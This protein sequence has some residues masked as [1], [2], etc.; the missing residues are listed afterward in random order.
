M[1]TYEYVKSDGAMGTVQ[2]ENAD[3][4]IKLAPG[5]AKNSG[6]ALSSPP[7]TSSISSTKGINTIKN[8]DKKM[9]ELDP[10]KIDPV[11]GRPNMSATDTTS[12]PS[13]KNTAQ[14]YVE[15]YNPTNERTMKISNVNQN[16]NQIK[17]LMES[18]FE[19][20]E[21]NTT[22]QI[23]YQSGQTEPTQQS[24]DKILKEEQ[25][26]LEQ[27]KTSNAQLAGQIDSIKADYDSRITIMR[28][29]GERREQSFQT[30][31]YR[32]GGRFTG[33]VRGGVF[34]GVISE[35]ER[36]GEARINT[37]DAQK[38]AEIEAAKQA[39]K[40]GNWKVYVQAVNNT[41]KIFEKQVKAVTDYNKAVKT[42]NDKLQKQLIE[43]SQQGSIIDLYKQG[44]T[45]PLDIYDYLNFDDSGNQIG[46]VS[47]TD[48]SSILGDIKKGSG[49]D[50]TP[51][52][53]RKL[54]QAGLIDAD[55][56]KQLDYLY[57]KK[58]K[59][60][61]SSS[62]KDYEKFLKSTVAKQT[63]AASGDI[64]KDQLDMILRNT[65][66]QGNYDTKSSQYTSTTVPTPIKTDL[67]DDISKGSSLQEI[68]TAY[69]EVSTSYISS[70]YNSLNK[71]GSSSSRSLTG[72]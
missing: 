15:L 39:Q 67:I 34:G 6:V 71:K 14:D 58:P 65:Y 59:A 47:F 42:Q 66:K 63:I 10:P 45:D 2:A 31:G 52:E 36:Q 50:Y 40:S 27:F 57:A 25:R 12:T 37:L 54:E 44:I 1:E 4:A 24:Y 35:E 46:D 3:N 53:Q 28:D 17:S 69:P 13:G 68:Y 64:S 49:G 56:Q 41:Q 43:T 32:I 55:R 7:Q 62:N 16:M 22:A 8:A 48:I 70:L 72:E 20:T 21:S 51:T 60:G 23:P 9:A 38:K 19:I 29:I 18:G 11:S 33:G 5:I 61:S 26:K 30:L